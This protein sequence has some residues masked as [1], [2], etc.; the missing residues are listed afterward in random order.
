LSLYK[1]IRVVYNDDAFRHQIHSEIFSLYGNGM[2]TIRII[3]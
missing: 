2:G 1:Y 3:I